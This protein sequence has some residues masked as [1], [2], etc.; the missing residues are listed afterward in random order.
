M[1]PD[2]K[3]QREMRGQARGRFF[4]QDNGLSPGKIVSGA[5]EE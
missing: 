1:K 3:R 5:L 4:M 2:S